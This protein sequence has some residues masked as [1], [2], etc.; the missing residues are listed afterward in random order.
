PKGAVLGQL[1]DDPDRVRVPMIREGT[2]W[3]EAT[4]E[5]A[6]ARAEEL[7][8]G[9]LARH[10]KPAIT[11]YIGN[12][13]VHNLSISRYIGL[14]VGMAD[15]QT[16]YSAGTVDQWPKNLTAALMFGHMWAIAV[17]DVHRTDYLVVM[18]ANPADSQGSLLA[19]PDMLGAL[20]AIRA[21]GG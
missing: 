5:A 9:V 19:C 13:T 17:P 14:F 20:D 7:I 11:A 16:L 2:T 8:A 15:L 21:R 4:W 3:R 10:G 1:H 6:F 18:G 12:P